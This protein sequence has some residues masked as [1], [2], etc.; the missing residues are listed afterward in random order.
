MDSYTPALLPGLFE[1]SL[2]GQQF[3]TLARGNR[4]VEPAKGTDAVGQVG[5]GVADWLF[6]E[7]TPVMDHRQIGPVG[8]TVAVK[9]VD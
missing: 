3:D 2:V 5:R 1:R 7:Q 4:V 6:A 8:V 9:Q